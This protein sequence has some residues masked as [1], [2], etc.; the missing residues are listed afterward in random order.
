MPA[1]A[2]VLSGE[3]SLVPADPAYAACLVGEP[4]SI[5]KENSIGGDW[6]RLR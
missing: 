5:I 4:V 1:R 6:L 3:I 2:A